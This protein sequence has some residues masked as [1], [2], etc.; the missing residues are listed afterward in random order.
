M[1]VYLSDP[2]IRTLIDL[3]CLYATKDG[4]DIVTDDEDERERIEEMFSE[5]GLELILGY[6][7]DGWEPASSDLL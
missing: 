3:P 4:Y 1:E 2:L 5:I 6:W 7:G